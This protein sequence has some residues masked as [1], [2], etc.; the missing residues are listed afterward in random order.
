MVIFTTMNALAEMLAPLRAS[1]FLPEAVNELSALLAEERQRR[2]QFYQEMTPDMKVE[3]IEGEVILHSP[4]R[5]VHLDVTTRLAKLLSAY[6]DAQ[7]LGEIKVEKCLCVFPRNDY[8]PDVVFFS[9]EKAAALG[10]N[11]MKFP[12]PDLIV[13]VLSE[14]TEHRDRGVKFQDYEAHGV[15]EY[16]IVDAEQ[17][18]VEQYVLATGRYDLK[19]KSG[20]GTLSSGVVTGFRVPVE[21]FFDSKA[22]TEALRTLLA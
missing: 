6:V 2:D 17:R 3:F 16:W 11:T 7:E 13:E 21:A 5:N 19:M 18:A 20:T 1:P 9:R 15:Q 14:S 4:A 8:E 12:V 22:N 10:N